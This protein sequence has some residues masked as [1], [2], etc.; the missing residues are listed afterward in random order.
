MF[1]LK[2]PLKFLNAIYDLSSH[3]ITK[4]SRETHLEFPYQYKGNGGGDGW[5]R[6]NIYEC[7]W[8]LYW[9]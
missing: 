5:L 7:H 8:P 4:I 6:D 3:K 9:L 1:Y 2:N